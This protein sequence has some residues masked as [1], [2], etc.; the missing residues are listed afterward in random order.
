MG[1]TLMKIAKILLIIG[2]LNLGLVGI[3]NF[4]FIITIFGDGL[5]SDV[6]Y[7]L[8]GLSAVWTIFMRSK[9]R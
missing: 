1:N 6:I 3:A 8:I 4:N 2:G 7:I 5:I 9:R